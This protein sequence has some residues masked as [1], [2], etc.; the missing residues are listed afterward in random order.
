MDSEINIKND[1]TDARLM[2]KAVDFLWR[3][4]VT[5]G[6]LAVMG[7]NTFDSLQTIN[8]I[9]HGAKEY[10]PVTTNLIQH[11]GNY[12]YLAIKEAGALAVAGATYLS[13]KGLVSETKNKF[14]VNLPAMALYAEAAYFAVAPFVNWHYLN[15]L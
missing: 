8:G 7:A 9:S 6:L 15:H 5:I 2:N 1:A 13:L 10:N 11:Y 14:L 3:N 12:G 4:K